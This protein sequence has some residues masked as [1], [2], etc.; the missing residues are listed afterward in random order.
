M[1]SNKTTKSEKFLMEEREIIDIVNKCKNNMSTDCDGMDKTIVKNVIET[2]FQPLTS[3][4][5]L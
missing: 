3:M 2:R 5:N 4:C 1:S